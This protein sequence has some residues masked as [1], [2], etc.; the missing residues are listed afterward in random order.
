MIS[1]KGA[2]SDKKNGGEEWQQERMQ[3][4]ESELFEL[5]L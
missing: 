5:L 3:K 2:K 1:K 4:K